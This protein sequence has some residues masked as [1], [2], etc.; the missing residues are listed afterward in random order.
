MRKHAK[1]GTIDT[2]SRLV[3]LK[4]E[5]HRWWDNLPADTFCKDP[6]PLSTVRRSDAHLKLEFCLVRMFTGRPFITPHPRPRANTSTPS[7]PNSPEPRTDYRSILIADCV[8][9]ALSII[10]TCKLLRSTIGLA[11]ASYTEFS[12]CR[13]ALLVI[14]TQCL[15]ERTERSREALREGVAMIKVMSAGGESARS[16]ASLIEVFERA[17]TRLDA[18]AATGEGN[19]GDGSGES[20]YARFKQWEML[21]KQSISGSG[22]PV[23]PMPGIRGGPGL[24]R[25]AGQAASPADW[26]LGSFPQ[27]LGEFSMFGPGFSPGPDGATG[28]GMDDLWMGL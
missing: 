21:W 1:Q 14:V 28:L 8:D 9:A 17:I 25:T 6:N 22:G 27:A 23:T 18:A 12:A 7:S 26:G 5:V 4:N 13:A 2:L 19:G 24:E 11:R 3:E 16:E 20:E 10:D 15:G